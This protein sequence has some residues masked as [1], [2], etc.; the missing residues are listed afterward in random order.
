MF[1][2]QSVVAALKT[3]GFFALPPAPSLRVAANI[4]LFQVQLPIAS[5][6]RDWLW[7][8]F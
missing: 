3:S 7:A 6:S 2:G 5:V 8:K 4:G 1:Y